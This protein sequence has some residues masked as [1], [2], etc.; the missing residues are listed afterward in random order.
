MRCLEEGDPQRSEKLR[1]VDL[2][3]ESGSPPVPQERSEALSHCTSLQ[4]S[5]ALH[6][7]DATLQKRLQDSF[8]PSSLN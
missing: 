7:I 6:I 5:P 3:T 8:H 2:F 4:P 1:R